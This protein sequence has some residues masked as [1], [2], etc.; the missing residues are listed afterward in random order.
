MAKQ[1]RKL[2][3][4]A[5]FIA[6]IGFQLDP[7][8]PSA[9]S[10]PKL[11]D[12]LVND[13][14]LLKENGIILYELPRYLSSNQ[15]KLNFAEMALLKVIPFS[16]VNYEK[17]QY[18]DG[19]IMPVENMDC[20][21]QLDSYT[22]TI[23][24]VSPVNSGWY[25][26]KPNS[27]IYAYFHQ[28]ALWRLMK[29]WDKVKGW[30]HSFP[31]D[32]FYT[33]GQKKAISLWDFNGSDMDQGLFTYF[34]LFFYGDVMLIDTDVKKVI[35]YE[36]GILHDLAHL[37]V[38][39]DLSLLK[40]NHGNQHHSAGKTDK[41]IPKPNLQSQQQIQHDPIQA[42]NEAFEKGDSVS[43]SKDNSQTTR[44]LLPVETYWDLKAPEVSSAIDFLKYKKEIPVKTALSMCNGKLPTNAFIHYT[45]RSKP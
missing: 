4:T 8:N 40:A 15:Y 35:Y 7:S 2:G 39:S 11:K 1:L 13:L 34:F 12:Y 16:M 19:D 41:P 37:P 38:G 21:F 18:F 9:S 31:K 32:I 6:M 26:L 33:R 5:D 20:Y 23:G 24:A 22:Y 17:I 14:N 36:K 28:Q 44:P 29:D 10:L 30:G 27:Q 43:L 25:L 3:S 45:G 42:I